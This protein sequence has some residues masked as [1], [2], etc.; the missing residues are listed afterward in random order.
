MLR[1]LIAL[2]INNVSHARYTLQTILYVHSN[3]KC[4][5]INML[6]WLL[7][8]ISMRNYNTL[9]LSE[10][11]IIMKQECQYIDI[12]VQSST[13]IEINTYFY[14]S[15]TTHMNINNLKIYNDKKVS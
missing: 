8:L 10:Y 7:K 3:A 2:I 14:S 6:S 1:E 15:A 13:F 4:N 5:G 11:D 9:L 12:K